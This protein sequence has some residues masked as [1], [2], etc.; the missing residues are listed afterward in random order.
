[1]T[2]KAWAMFQAAFPQSEEIDHS[3]H[4]NVVAPR[5]ADP[6]ELEPIQNRLKLLPFMVWQFSSLTFLNLRNLRITPTEL[7]DLLKFPNLAALVLEQ[8]IDHSTGPS[9]DGIG[10]DDLFMRRWGTAID[11]MGAFPKLKLLLFRHFPI[12]LDDSFKCFSN[13]PSLILC[14]VCSQ[15]IHRDVKGMEGGQ[16]ISKGRWRY[17]PTT[18]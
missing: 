7:V 12:Y 14:N 13:F 5:G 16:L 6:D 8:N 11:E 9:R 4:T 3:Y 18:G 17:L 2:L 10:I 15:W 1:M